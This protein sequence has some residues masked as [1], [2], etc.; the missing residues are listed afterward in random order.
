MNRIEDFFYNHS[1]LPISKRAHYFKIY[2]RHLSKF[3][4]T[5]PT[6]LQLGAR[7]GGNIQ[8]VEQYFS[9]KCKI[10]V[11]DGDHTIEEF[12]SDNV[13]VII[14]DIADL[15]LYDR[16]IKNYDSPDIIIDDMIH[17]PDVQKQNFE[18]LFGRLNPGGIYLVEGTDSSYKDGITEIGSFI[19][20]T[21]EFV[22]SI[23]APRTVGNSSINQKTLR[24]NTISKWVDFISFYDSIFVA[25]K[26][27]QQRSA[28]V[29]TKGDINDK[30]ITFTSLRQQQRDILLRRKTTANGKV[31]NKVVAN[32]SPR[33]QA[34]IS[35]TNA[36][37]RQKALVNAAN[38]R[39]SSTTPNV[40]AAKVVNI[41]GTF[42][43]QPSVGQ[44]I[45]RTVGNS[46]SARSM[47]P[48]K[49]NQDYGILSDASH[50][51][52]M[53]DEECDE[54]AAMPNV[55]NGIM[56]ASN[57][58][59]GNGIMTGALAGMSS[60]PTVSLMKVNQGGSYNGGLNKVGLNT[61]DTT[62][63]LMSTDLTSKSKKKRRLDVGKFM[64][65]I[66]EKGRR[67]GEKSKE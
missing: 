64:N 63:Q 44:V 62:S 22:D 59:V 15:N 14:A 23:H 8:M 38:L 10:I 48:T 9:D 24:C 54:E 45:N 51:N 42:G 34:S 60:G 29:V 13:K 28:K 52:Y 56:T 26:K 3:V 6:I 61:S 35:Q 4:G 40:N 5:E 66:R 65:K 16:I 58:N 39:R 31:G 12:N 1:H 47:T 30:D 50:L 21:K 57:P 53:N 11:V 37:Q 43:G 32:G 20:Y 36:A 18:H 19:E 2:D 27:Q 55:N 17:D 33:A 46:R 41:Q 25:E 49:N 67:S 7:G